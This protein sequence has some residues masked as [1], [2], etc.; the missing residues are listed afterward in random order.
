MNYDATG[1]PADI[2]K[3]FFET[4]PSIFR[5]HSCE[6]CGEIVS[7]DASLTPNHN[8]IVQ[9]GLRCLQKALNF[10]PKLFDASCECGKKCTQELLANQ[11]T[12]RIRNSG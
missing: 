2:W 4:T 1:S 3:S 5:S 8:I 6:N 10:T 12:R 11:H 9:Q 7:C